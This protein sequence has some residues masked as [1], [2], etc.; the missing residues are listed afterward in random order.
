MKMYVL[1][2]KTLATES[3]LVNPKL[4]NTLKCLIRDR[5]CFWALKEFN[6]VQ[7]L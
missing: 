2:F 4:K 6:Q 5:H 7:P 1:S 3:H